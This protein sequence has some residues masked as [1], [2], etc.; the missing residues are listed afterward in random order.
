MKNKCALVT[1]STGFIGSNLVR[2]LALDGWET[3]VLI[4]PNSNLDQIEDIKSQIH[5]HYHS[6]EVGPLVNMIKEIQPTVVFHL[7]S[8]FLANHNSEDVDNLISS[9]ILFPAQLIEAMARNDCINLVNTGTAWQH[10]DS[11]EFNP[12]NF[13]SSTKQA[14]EDILT[15]YI[16]TKSIKCITLK[17]FDTYG[18][19]DR[20]A[21]LIRTLTNLSVS[22]ET[23]SMSP[24]EQKID[25]VYID[26]V[27]DAYILAA[28]RLMQN[29]VRSHEQY[30][31]STGV[32]I[33]IRD[34]VNILSE[35]FERPINV[36]WGGRPYRPREVM[37][38]WAGG[39]WL[40]G[41]HPKITLDK[42]LRLIKEGFQHE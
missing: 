26:D 4:R 28:L 7:A 8:L 31:V 9:N 33:S 25:L 11:N 13:Y 17:L 27:V 19:K 18:P 23:L 2:K 34:L 12:V 1:G 20:R 21:K 3:H 35:V 16:Q 39:V 38:P 42:G 14:F 30:S 15:F 41:W 29:K 36:S 24:G 32:P 22:G 37:V 5:L 40:D 6:G 10:Y